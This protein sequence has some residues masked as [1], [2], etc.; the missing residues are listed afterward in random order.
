MA[1]SPQVSTGTYPVG[2]KRWYAKEDTGEAG[3]LEVSAT[4]AG[5]GLRAFQPCSP[6]EGW[7]QAGCK[8]PP[9]GVSAG[10]RAGE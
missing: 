9:T 2:L 7:C 10:W 5:I 3:R 1:H 6:M 4:F 8:R